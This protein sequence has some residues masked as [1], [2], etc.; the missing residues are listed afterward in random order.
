MSP[1]I[2]GAP[3]TSVLDFALPE[4]YAG[5]RQPAHAARHCDANA[6]NG[7]RL[8]RQPQLQWASRRC[9]TMLCVPLDVSWG[10]GVEAGGLNLLIYPATSPLLL[11]ELQFSIH[12]HFHLTIQPSLGVLTIQS[13][14]GSS[15]V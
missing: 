4:K 2:T 5:G 7:T 1:F 9:Q 11:R 12:I 8:A 13:H 3:P 10:R 6:W 14:S 15:C